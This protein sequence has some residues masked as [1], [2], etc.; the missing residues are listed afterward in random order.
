M[1]LSELYK[2][3]YLPVFLI[4]LVIAYE[5]LSAGWEKLHGSQFVVNIGKTFIRF[6]DGNPHAWYVDSVLGIAKIHPFLFAQLVQ[7]GELLAGVGLA[8]AI[9]SHLSKNTSLR[10]VARYGAILSL[11]GAAFMSLN[12]YF[13]AGWTSASTSGL[14]ALMFW[15]EISLL[16]FWTYERKIPCVP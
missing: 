4:Q 10:A 1:K 5:W 2:H 14:N 11:L 9:I 16:V 6:G 3:P 7:W 8:F 13:A 15:T 12:F